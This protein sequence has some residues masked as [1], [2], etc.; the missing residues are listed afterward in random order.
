MDFSHRRIS[1]TLS[2]DNGASA[3][4][5]QL[6]HNWKNPA[7]ALEYISNSR[8]H[9]EKMASKIQNTSTKPCTITSNAEVSESSAPIIS[10]QEPEIQSEP[11]AKRTKFEENKDQSNS[12]VTEAAVGT[13][14][15][16]FTNC[17]VNVYVQK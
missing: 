11:A 9:R 6:K 8:P 5:M 10:V 1:A 12:S 17:T 14:F 15:G 7:M 13:V 2:A 16:G 4:E 3:L